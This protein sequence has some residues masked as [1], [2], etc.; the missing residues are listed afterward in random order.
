MKRIILLLAVGATL[1]ALIACKSRDADLAPQGKV[2]L[3]PSKIVTPIK[4]GATGQAQ[5]FSAPKV[6]IVFVMDNSLSMQPA[7]DLLKANVHYLVES[8]AQAKS[9][10]VRIAVTTIWDKER[11]RPDKVAPSCTNADGTSVFNY[12]GPGAALPL[13]MPAGLEADARFKKF[14]GQRFLNPTEDGAKEVLEAS[15]LVGTVLVQD[16]PGKCEQGPIVESVLYPI[17]KSLKSSHM[18]DFW[19]EG[20]LKVFIVLS[21]AQE[22]TNLTAERVDRDIRKALAITPEDKK[23]ITGGKQDMYRVY[24]AGMKPGVPVSRCKADFGGFKGASSIPDHEIAKLA[25]LSGGEIFSI[26]DKD[27]GNK[28]AGFGEDIKRATLKN[29]IYKIS[30][31]NVNPKLPKE[32]QLKVMLGDQPLT[33]GQIQP[34]ATG[35]PKIMGNA[36]WGYDLIHDQIVVRGDFWNDHPGAGLTVLYVPAP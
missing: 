18:K 33:Q 35:E 29:Q 30:P 7:Q 6:D 9:I 19:R 24:V 13:K 20:S 2:T 4:V 36:D 14:E 27:Y 26:C 11:Y 1:S 25:R 16:Q 17:S 22:A 31:V 5:I 15:I 21:D 10:D 34:D 28:L 12:F 3:T 8:L 23:K 32:K